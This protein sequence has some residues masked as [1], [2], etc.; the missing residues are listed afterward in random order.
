MAI[1]LGSVVVNVADLELMTA[2]WAEALGHTPSSRDP[3]DDFRCL[4]EGIHLVWNT[5]IFVTD[6]V[7]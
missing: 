2:F 1:R 3:G 7:E 6:H 4:L 5:K